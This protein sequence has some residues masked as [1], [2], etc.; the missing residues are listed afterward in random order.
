MTERPTE[1]LGTVMRADTMRRIASEA[2]FTGFERL[3]K[4]ELDMLRFYLLTS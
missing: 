2:G 1:A 4:P 3:E